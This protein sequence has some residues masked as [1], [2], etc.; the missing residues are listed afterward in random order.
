MRLIGIAK[1]RQI[2]SIGQICFCYQHGLGFCT[3][4]QSAEQPNYGMGLRLIDA[5][6]SRGFPNKSDG[7]ESKQANT[8]IQLLSDDAEEL[9]KNSWITKIEVD[10]ISAEGTPN[11]S[12]TID[13]IN[14]HK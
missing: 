8:C 2:F 3:L 7:V 10:L 12:L 9:L 4:H 6:R 5:G 11:Q 13:G 14:R 1:V